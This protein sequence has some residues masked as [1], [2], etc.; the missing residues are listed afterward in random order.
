MA[1]VKSSMGVSLHRQS[2][3]E[4]RIESNAEHG[5]DGN[6]PKVLPAYRLY[7]DRIFLGH[8]HRSF[9]NI[10]GNETVM[11][12]ESMLNDLNVGLPE[13]VKKPIRIANTRKRM[14]P[15]S[16]EIRQGPDFIGC[17]ISAKS[18]L[19][20]HP[21]GIGIICAL[22]VTDAEIDFSRQFPEGPGRQ[23][24]A[25]AIAT[26]VIDDFD[27]EASRQ[28]LMLQPIVGYNDIASSS[29]EEF[30]GTAAVGIHTDR[31]L[32]SPCNQ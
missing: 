13:H 22:A 17:Q 5:I 1:T 32:A 9:R 24:Q 28:T 29:D 19:E 6:G 10:G 12:R 23:Q 11:V 2:A 30:G 4:L 15:A 16:G 27:L 20:F 8:Q 25:V 18:R 7:L 3:V 26:G 14:H 31:N 21:I